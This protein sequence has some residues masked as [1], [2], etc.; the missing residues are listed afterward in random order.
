MR[1]YQVIIIGAGAA[2]LMCALTAGQ[3]GRKVL[4]LDHSAQVGNKILISGGKR[5]NFTNLWVR[6]ENY[7]SDNPKFCKSALSRF[8]PDIF[9]SLLEKH[10]IFYDEKKAG[11]LFC[12]REAREI[13]NLLLEECRIGAVSIQIN[14]EIK[15]IKKEKKFLISASSGD[16]TSDSLVIATGGLSMP[17]TG[18]SGFGYDIAKQFGLNIIPTHP[19]LVPLI[20]NRNAEIPVFQNGDE[21]A[22]ITPQSIEKISKKFF[23]CPTSRGSFNFFRD[24][25]GISVKATVSCTTPHQSAI[26]TMARRCRARKTFREDILFTHKGLSGPAILQIS[27]Y[28]NKGDEIIINLLPYIDLAEKI[29]EWQKQKPK[30][31]LKNLISEF[32][33]KRLVQK[34]LK[35]SKPAVPCTAHGTRVNQYN[36]KE[37]G[38]IAEI[39]HKWKIIPSG[40]EGYKVAEVTK[41]GVDT[42]ELSSKTF[43]CHKVKGL[44]FIGEVLDVTGEL[45]GY[46]LHWAWASGYSAG[47]FV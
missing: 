42:R 23:R 15:K 16:Y 46:N 34:F 47:Q 33:P 12:M 32:L 28:W 22:T 21:C 6:G 17:E 20:F 39:F 18:T 25:A 40:T 13:V 30:V 1:D 24:L 11:Q 36:K 37:I 29:T 5:C 19:G 4:L 38:K 26:D 9:L 14:C 35:L 45:G 3:R 31:E 41:G 7:I 27:N 43:E 2:G 10:G 8:T 44:Y